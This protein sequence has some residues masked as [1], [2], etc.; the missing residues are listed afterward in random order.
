MTRP[1]I[2]AAV[3]AL[4][5]LTASAH[6]GQACA[7]LLPAGQPTIQPAGR[8]KLL[9]Y[10]AYAVLYSSQ[11]RTALWSAERLTRD[12][13]DAARKLPRDS[14]FYEEEQLPEADRARLTD[15][16]R[17][18]GIDR[19]HLAPSGDF[20]D[21]ASQAESFS[22]ANVIPQDSVSNRR[23]WSHIETSTRRLARQHGT[24][25][26]VTGPAFVG[27]P[28]MLGRVR[29]PDFI[30]KAIYVPG[31]GAAVYIVRN[32]ATP[33]YSV[34]SIAEL[35]HFAGIDPFPELSKTMNTKAMDLPP[36]TPHPGEKP[37]RRVAF[38]WLA[39]GEAAA[40][41][42]APDSLQH[43]VRDANAIL[44]LALAYAR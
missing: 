38:A 43:V 36:P 32:D 16:R 3:L 33:A 7:Q 37:A 29:V 15:Y 42:S 20:P 17:G 19:G 4:A 22:L 34:I 1:L 41:L 23:T 8:T 18:S 40:A 13:V 44:S 14:D 25:Q 27:V 6:T 31:V 28:R 5:S 11:T 9:C 12:A 35:R 2:A 10:R 21:K 24:I 30:W 39:S 26:V